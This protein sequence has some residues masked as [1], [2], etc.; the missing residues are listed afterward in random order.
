MGDVCIDVERENR[1]KGI[2]WAGDRWLD[3]P[4]L[5]GSVGSLARE[6]RDLKDQMILME[7]KVSLLGADTESKA[8]IE[9]LERDGFTVKPKQESVMRSCP[10]CGHDKV[11]LSARYCPMC[12]HEMKQ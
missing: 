5:E 8:A 4:G 9:L 10:E 6:V 1:S 3:V 11:R 2:I 12:A 7:R